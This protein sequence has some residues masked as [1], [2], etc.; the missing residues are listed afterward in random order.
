MGL[1]GGQSYQAEWTQLH[2]A[3]ATGNLE[4][5]IWWL[6]NLANPA[7]QMISPETTVT[8]CRA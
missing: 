8:Q 7:V 2:E 5:A 4:D 1:S 3:C 6:D